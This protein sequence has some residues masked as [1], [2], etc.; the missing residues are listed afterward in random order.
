MASLMPATA[1]LIPSSA[2][3]SPAEVLET[4]ASSLRRL[5]TL[6][7]LA[8]GAWALAVYESGAV[9]QQTVEELRRAIAPLALVELSLLQ[10]ASPD[11]LRILLRYD[12]EAEG[13]A[14]VLSFTAVGH[15]LDEL[16]GFLDIQR[17][18]LAG[19]PHRLLFWVT[20]G[21][22]RQLAQRAPNFY[23][24]LSGIF[25][26]PGGVRAGAEGG[27]MV[28]PERT[29]AP[30]VDRTGLAG[31]RR[32]Y[33]PANDERERRRL[34]DFLRRRIQELAALPRP[35]F[36]AIGD[37][38][39][40]L[41][42]VYETGM[43]RL[44]AE[45]EAA[46]AEAARAYARS[47]NTPAEA[48]ARYQAGDAALRSYSP[49]TALEHLEHALQLY[50]LLQQ[51]PTGTPEAVRGEANVLL[52]QGRVLAFLDRRE[53]ALACYEQALG[54]YRAVGDRLGEANVLQAQGDVLRQQ[55]HYE[56][57]HVQYQAALE[58]YRAIGARQGEANAYHGLGRLALA[59]GKAEDARRWTERAIALH[60]ATGS[61]YD[62]ALDCT[63]LAQAC[64]AAG[65]IEGAMA[66]WRC[67]ADNY[68]AIGLDG[69]AAEAM[70]VLGDLL[71]EAGR[72]Q[73]ALA[74]YA[75]AV[76]LAPNDA[77]FRRDYAH[78]LITLGRLDEAAAQLDAA[79]ALEPD[80]PYLALRRA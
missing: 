48:D 34:E 52:E 62:V 67:A 20:E 72:P 16:A 47:G 79:E 8:P 19:Y 69:Q 78:Q 51:S 31:R 38:W 41:A 10:E 60:E 53:E 9:L 18:R 5:A 64:K 7:R 36:N 46:Y 2:T 21:E 14:P 44:W 4:R 11:P 66:A 49:Q 63:T 73:E 65:D 76:A 61:R 23:S 75:E 29:T 22:R 59:Q 6:L 24:R 30:T 37:A 12:G 3:L 71:Q 58:R 1:E 57:A 70:N 39:Y 13:D 27:G 54:L 43:P 45:A 17:D 40:D 68:R 35:D 74:A 55:G 42:G 77:M 15:R 56:A 50:R 33:L 32:P 28:L 80:A 26:F 25:Y